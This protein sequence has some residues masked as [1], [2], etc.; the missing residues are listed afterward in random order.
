M[1]KTL[2]AN[3]TEFV[4]QTKSD[5]PS[6]IVDLSVGKAGWE[7]LEKNIIIPQTDPY[8]YLIQSNYDGGE[9]CAFNPV[10]DDIIIEETMLEIESIYEHVKDIMESNSVLGMDELVI[11]SDLLS[12]YQSNK[13]ILKSFDLEDM[14]LIEHQDLFFGLD[15]I[16]MSELEDKHGFGHI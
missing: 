8:L 9:G 2:M 3:F 1:T 11:L 15:E 7:S 14:I 6:P 13:S 4:R 12:H 10:E 5:E 16:I